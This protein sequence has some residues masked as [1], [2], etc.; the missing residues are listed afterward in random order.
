MIE[1]KQHQDNDYVF[2][3]K[4]ESGHTLLKSTPFSSKK[5]AKT[6]AGNL[7]E[8][9]HKPAIFER[10]TNHNGQFLFSLKNDNGQLLGNSQLYNSEAGMENGI[11]NTIQRIKQLAS[12][13]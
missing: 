8:L 6:V 5:E 12:L 11:K 13:K 4:S 10:K 9:V 7:N 2:E 1:V 3:L